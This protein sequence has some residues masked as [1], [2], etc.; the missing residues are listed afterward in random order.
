MAPHPFIYQC[1]AV[2]SM[3]ARLSIER[4]WWSPHIALSASSRISVRSEQRWVPPRY[5]RR[6]INIRNTQPRESDQP[7]Q[8]DSCIGF[9]GVHINYICDLSWPRVDLTQFTF[10][11]LKDRL[12]L[13]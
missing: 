10:L 6:F 13:P 9:S 7:A 12:Q 8:G 3:A 1:D 4:T 5:E 2:A 11:T